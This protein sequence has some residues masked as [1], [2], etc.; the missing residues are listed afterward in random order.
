MVIKPQKR[1]HNEIETITETDI[2]D[3]NT[4]VEQ[5]EHPKKTLRLIDDGQKLFNKKTCIENI[6]F[7][8]SE[9]PVKLG[10]IERDA[11]VSAGYLARLEKDSNT[12]DPSIEFLLVASK[13][14]GI[15]LDTLVNT[16]LNRVTKSEEELIQFLI[17]LKKDTDNDELAWVGD[18]LE[19]LESYK[20]K[21][22]NEDH[23]HPL[24]SYVFTGYEISYFTYDSLFFEEKKIKP[25]DTGYHT[26]LQD[27]EDEIYMMKVIEEKEDTPEKEFIELYHVD[28][29]GQVYPIC[30]TMQVSKEI[31]DA[32][33]MLYESAAV[34]SSHVRLAEK[35]RSLIGSYLK[36]A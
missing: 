3:I 23:P 2:D 32:V 17:Q 36:K 4:C 26:K 8:L 34:S 15:F 35:T 7:L 24:F 6:R 21:D 10:D 29:E 31:T 19:K 9:R 16:K 13:K 27:S 30:N 28:N 33:E 14:F 18:S 1:I 22:T 12:T 25:S 20:Q 11:G 5:Q